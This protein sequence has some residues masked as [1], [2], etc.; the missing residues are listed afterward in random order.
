[1]PLMCIPL[2]NDTRTPGKQRNFTIL[3]NRL[4]WLSISP[5]F[6][7]YKSRVQISARQKPA[8]TTVLRGFPQ[9]HGSMVPVAKTISW[10]MLRRSSSFSRGMSLEAV[11]LR[12]LDLIPDRSKYFFFLH[13]VHTSFGDSP[14]IFGV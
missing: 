14:S 8:S 3:P 1:M 7:Y 11:L 13:S 10:R 4:S 6:R 9:C 2:R 5:S 12:N